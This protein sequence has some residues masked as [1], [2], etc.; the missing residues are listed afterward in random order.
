MRPKPYFFEGFRLGLEL[1]VA[2]AGG[3]EAH[4]AFAMGVAEGLM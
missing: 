3:S 4:V 1:L 2:L